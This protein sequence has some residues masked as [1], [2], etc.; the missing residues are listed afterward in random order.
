MGR[1]LGMVSISD[2]GKW[3]EQ[4]KKKLGYSQHIEKAT[5]GDPEKDPKA[6]KEC[7]KRSAITY[8]AGAK[9]IPVDISTGIHDGHK[10]SVPISQALEAFN[11]LAKPEDRISE[12]DIKY[13]VEKE[14]VP[15]HLAMKE[16]EFIP[17][18]KRLIHF[19]R[20]REMSG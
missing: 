20:S 18:T 6:A 17:T 3:H 11:I 1:M 2:I 14:A 9:D 5:G 19:R 13:F 12:E 4:C 15:P 16:K 8:L 10:G 7:K